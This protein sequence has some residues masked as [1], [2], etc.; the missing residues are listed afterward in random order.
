MNKTGIGKSLGPC[1][2][3]QIITD[4]SLHSRSK[5]REG[6]FRDMER[7][8]LRKQERLENQ[9]QLQQQIELT[10]K[11]QKTLEASEKG[12]PAS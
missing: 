2:V 4:T 3:A 1:E 8:E 12:S 11:L 9:L 7:Q 5:L 6:V 10:E